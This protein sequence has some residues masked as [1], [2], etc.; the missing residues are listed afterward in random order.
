MLLNNNTLLHFI[1]SLAKKDTHKGAQPNEDVQHQTTVTSLI[2]LKSIFSPR[3]KPTAVN[4]T[5]N[6]CMNSG[7]PTREIIF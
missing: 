1:I 2:P 6:S 7:R 5:Q 3:E 4:Y